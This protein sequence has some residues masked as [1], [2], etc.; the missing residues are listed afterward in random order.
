MRGEAV[1]G[2]LADVAAA[3]FSVLGDCRCQ[4]PGPQG[5]VEHFV[6]AR[7]D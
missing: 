2:A 5:N 3:G 6:L 7:R 1:A 4:V